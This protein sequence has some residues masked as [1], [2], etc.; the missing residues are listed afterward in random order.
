MILSTKQRPRDVR[1]FEIGKGAQRV[2]NGWYENVLQPLTYGY[3]VVKEIYDKQQLYNWA[4][5]VYQD[6][7][8]NRVGNNQSVSQQGVPAYG[9]IG[10]KPMG[11][12][13]PRDPYQYINIPYSEADRIARNPDPN[14]V[15][16]FRQGGENVVYDPSEIGWEE[17]LPEVVV[18]GNL[19]KK[20]NNS[21]RRTNNTSKSYINN[22]A[23][24]IRPISQFRALRIPTESAQVS[25]KPIQQYRSL[26]NYGVKQ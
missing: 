26:Y 5:S 22:R 6:Q 21:K 17:E 11:A 10:I 2:L 12:D 8:N 20:R 23:E 9:S 25:Y 13:G 1:K 16:R 15:Y 4:N 24:Y 3:D 19:A 18:T 14:A 7:Y